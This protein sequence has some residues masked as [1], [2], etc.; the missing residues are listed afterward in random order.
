METRREPGSVTL[1]GIRS[2]KQDPEWISKMPEHSKDEFIERLL[3]FVNGGAMSLMVSLGHRS[4]LFD[5]MA[6]LPPSTSGEI[7]QAGGLNERYVREWL[8]AMVAGQVI[9][10]DGES[11]RY[12]LP[13]EHAALL[14]RAATPNN[15]ATMAQWIAVLGGV[16]DR[17]LECFRNGGGLCY[18]EY[19]RFHEVMAEESS[20]TTVAALMDAILPLVGNLPRRLSAGAQALD[21]GC[22]SGEA[23]LTMARAYPASRF[24]GYELC[25]DALEHARAEAHRR[26]LPNVDFVSR[27]A[28]LID[29]RE[30]FDL[31]TAFDAIHDQARPDLVLQN[32]AKALKPDGVFLMQ[33]IRASSRVEANA[34]NP[35]APFIYTIS[36]MHCMSVSLGQGGMG[37][38]AA[39][40]LEKAEEMLLSNGFRD[41]EIHDLPHDIQNS[42]FTARKAA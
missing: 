3:T 32:I 9:D 17:V 33:D 23:L 10:Y 21:V 27:D 39:W 42:Y 19:G 26:Q 4:G 14:C 20:Q 6:N 8:G 2:G 16:E 29:D 38:G 15:M 37:L 22:G 5:S 31:V 40:G 41:I 18:K 7:A 25:E 11:G 28:A 13:P 12:S 24:V 35:I 34:A 30:E 1:R 36:C